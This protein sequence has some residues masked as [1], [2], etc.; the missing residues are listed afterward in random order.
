MV[1]VLYIY[2]LDPEVRLWNAKLN[3]LCKNEKKQTI[4]ISIAVGN[5]DTKIII[6]L[7]DQTMQDFRVKYQEPSIGSENLAYLQSIEN[8]CN[9]MD[10][11]YW[12][13]KSAVE[14]HIN[15]VRFD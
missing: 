2:F 8:K 12:R 14:N 15:Q 13:E 10:R 9:C 7:F 4:T 11:I 5:Y 3:L 6:E 1:R